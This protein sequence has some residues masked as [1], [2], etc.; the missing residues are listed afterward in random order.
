[1]DAHAVE[2][3]RTQVGLELRVNSRTPNASTIEVG[4]CV[5]PG[6]LKH[7]EEKRAA[8]PH[9]LL[10][11][12]PEKGREQRFLVPLAQGMTYVAFRS[13]GL[14]VL[15]ATIVWSVDGYKKLHKHLLR[16]DDKFRTDVLSNEGVL[17]DDLDNPSFGYSCLGVRVD[18]RFF[19]KEP[20]AWLKAWVTFL[21]D[22]P[23]V[24]QCD[25][26]KR[27]WFAWLVQPIL[28][29]LYYPI[30]FV[31][32]FITAIWWWAFLGKPG[33]D[34]GPVFRIV[35]SEYNDIYIHAK[36]EKSVWNTWNWQFSPISLAIA[37]LVPLLGL[38]PRE[39]KVY[40]PLFVFI[41]SPGEFV[42]YLGAWVLGLYLG[43]ALG[44][45][46]VTLVGTLIPALSRKFEEAERQRALKETESLEQE[47]GFLVC[48]GGIPA[49]VSLGSLPP[50]RR[51]I[52]LRFEG[53]KARVCKPF[54]K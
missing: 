54:A 20:P 25:F 21:W 31:F 15:Q 42:I 34:F 30:K 10:V 45:L 38:L 46:I 2:D 6:A 39:G 27:S 1:M 16:S 32:F 35:R 24:D 12:K 48:D 22:T 5:L 52:R 44:L 18:S 36:H 26:K 40:K 13:P 33:V 50:G 43:C 14:N 9:V 19:A 7:L 49:P 29:A 37:S 41:H 8:N 28:L 53:L 3:L 4:W 17:L 51:T 47:L 23:L 11:V